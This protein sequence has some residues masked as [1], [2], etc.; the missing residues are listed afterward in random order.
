MKISRLHQ[1]LVSFAL[2]MAAHTAVSAGKN[3]YPE[4]WGT[5]PQIQTMDYRPLPGGYGNGSSTLAN[6]IQQNLDND[7]AAKSAMPAMTAPDFMTGAKG[8]YL[9]KGKWLAVNPTKAKGGTAQAAFPFPSGKYD[10]TLRIVGESDGQSTYQVA[11][12][13]VKV[14]E[15]KAPSSTE[16]FEEGP[17]FATMF[18]SVALD[19]GD[20]ITLSSQIASEDGKE[21][22]RARIAGLEF[23][24]ADEATKAAVAKL[25]AATPAKPAKPAGPALVPPRKPDGSGTVA[26]SGEL[27][28]WHKV[29]LMLDGPFAQERDNEPNPFTALALNVTFTHES[30]SPKYTVPGC[31]AAD[32]NAAESSAEFGTKWCAHLSPDKTG[33]W[34]YTES[35][36]RRS[37]GR[38]E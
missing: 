25:A 8:Y 6:W 19:S 29:T 14:G 27:K 38:R 1:L 33:V 11:V 10:V 34:S 28:Q 18:K 5:P 4:H 31:F 2:L 37:S 7:A 15:F 20:V 24:P 32:G 22:S 17:K 36:P 12:N 23:A 21:F 26:I 30:G 16:M 3:P 13:D 9:D 35:L